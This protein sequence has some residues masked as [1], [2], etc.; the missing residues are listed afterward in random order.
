M[1]VSARVARA[2]CHIAVLPPFGLI[3]FIENFSIL[4]DHRHRMTFKEIIIEK[5]TYAANFGITNCIVAN[6][7]AGFEI[8]GDKF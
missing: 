5:L 1:R 8:L 2:K 6:K 3:F 4:Y 7:L